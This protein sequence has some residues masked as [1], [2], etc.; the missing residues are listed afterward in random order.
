[1]Q[2]LLPAAPVLPTGRLGSHF[3][4]VASEMGILGTPGAPRLEGKRMVLGYGIQHGNHMPFSR[5]CTMP[6]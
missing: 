4:A 5:C 6:I 3:P 2:H 1:M